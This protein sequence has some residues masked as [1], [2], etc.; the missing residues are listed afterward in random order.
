MISYKE[1][2]LFKNKNIY[3]CLVNPK[4][5]LKNKNFGLRTPTI[6][7]NKEEIINLIKEKYGDF[8][9]GFLHFIKNLESYL[10]IRYTS[11]YKTKYRYLQLLKRN[12]A[13]IVFLRIISLSLTNNIEESNELFRSLI[14]KDNYIKINNLKLPVSN[15][16]KIIAYL[17][18]VI[19]GDGHLDKRAN[20]ILIVDGQ[21]DKKKLLFSKKYLQSINNLFYKEFN[22]KGIIVK[23]KTWWYY[24][25]SNKWLTRYFNHYFEIPFGKKSNI[26]KFPKILSGSNENY[27]WRGLMDTDGF[28]SDKNKNICLKSS[29]L[30]ILKQFGKFCIK[31]NIKYDTK[32]EIRGWS[33]R[34]F[35]GSI[36]KYA[37]SVGAFHPRKKGALIKHLKKGP[38]YKILKEI[39]KQFNPEII[40]IFKY[41]RPYK[42]MVYIKLNEYNKKAH[43]QEITKLINSIKDNFNVKITKIK[44][45]R[46]NDHYYICSKQFTEFIKKNATYELPWQPLNKEDINNLSKEWIL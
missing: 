15:F 24:L 42:S 32:K 9:K 31:N 8:N 17:T 2:S 26:V 43:K 16:N 44:R 45:N 6:E 30:K 40:K 21:S 20:Y 41:L 7:I 13:N 46:Y 18:G 23:R 10:G 25:I 27:F 14:I 22:I 4:E 29:S 28:I 39:N 35:S 34:I 36:L 19:V 11:V 33:F 12:K 1:D 3:S 5:D 37:K 38:T